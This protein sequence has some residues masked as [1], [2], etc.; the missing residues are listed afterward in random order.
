L[1]DDIA[2]PLDGANSATDSPLRVVKTPDRTRQHPASSNGVG[3]RGTGFASGPLT[4]LGRRGTAAQLLLVTDLACLILPIVWERGHYRAFLAA[5]LLS[6]TLFWSAD[7]YRPRLQ[8]FMLNEAPALLGCMLAATAI[9]ATLSALRHPT[10]GVATY[11]I[12][13]ASAITLALFGRA[14]SNLVI[15]QSRRRGLVRHPTIVVGS[16]PIADRLTEILG[17][18]RDYGLRLAGYLA[19]E[20]APGSPVA[21]NP[22]LGRIHSL[23][24]SIDSTGAEV[25]LVSNQGFKE[26]ELATIVSQALWNDCNIFLVPRL[27][28]LNHQAWKA[29]MIGSIPVVRLC[30]AGRL[31]LP[32]KIKRVFDIVVSALALLVLSPVFAA[33]AI[34][35]RIDVGPGIL[36]RQTRVGCDGRPFE[37][38]KF[39]SLRPVDDHE[40]GTRW[41]IQ[42]DERV[43]RF[44]KFMRRTS[45][46]ELPQL[47]TILRGDMTIVGP[48]PERPYFVDKFSKEEPTYCLRHRVPAGLTGLAQVNGLRGD[49]SIS[50]RSFFDNYYIDNWSL[51]LD[52]K[53]ILM[54]FSEVLFGNGG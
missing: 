2:S 25:I 9:I 34:A 30:R 54:T 43:S 35:V 33:C 51:W 13:A 21:V 4:Y 7:L 8:A 18:C 14:L 52:A 37:M 16:G 20:P 24:S 19:D 15:R 49:T 36:F 44:G 53:V 47:W 6:C 1:P 50:E 39:R 3:R 29:D 5:A 32:W 45:L 17:S 28:Q 42:N 41:S 48:R 11:L 12:G 27:H 46:D 38:L 23:R 10:A 22:Y 31:G 40:S 26:E